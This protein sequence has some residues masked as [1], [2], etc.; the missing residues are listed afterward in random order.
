[1]QVKPIHITGLKFQQLVGWMDGYLAVALIL[2]DGSTLEHF[3]ILFKK[4]LMQMINIVEI[5]C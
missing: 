2:E 1:M 5:T 4:K 3:N